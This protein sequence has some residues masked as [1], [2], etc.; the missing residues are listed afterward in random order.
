MKGGRLKLFANQTILNKTLVK[1]V[2][3]L[4]VDASIQKPLWQQKK[5][6]SS[7]VNCDKV[8]PLLDLPLL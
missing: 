2:V 8:L 4:F 3:Y 5:M 6:Y 1:K 7:N